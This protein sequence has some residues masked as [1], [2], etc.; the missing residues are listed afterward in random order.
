[1]KIN[2]LLKGIKILDIKGDDNRDVMGVEI[3]SR[4]ISSSYMFV[5]MRG[6]VTDGHTYIAKAIEKGASVIV[7]EELPSDIKE[8]VTYVRVESTEDCVGRISTVFHGNPSAHLRLVGVTGTNGKTTI[9]TLLYNMFRKF[10]HK[11]GLI[12]TVCNY[13]DE[14]K[15]ETTHTTPDAI[16]LN[17]LLAE[18]LEAG[19]EYVF[20]ECSSHAIVQKRI[21]GLTFAGGIFTNLTRD[22]LDYHKTFYYPGLEVCH[23]SDRI[24]MDFR[25][26]VLYHYLS[27]LIVGI[28]K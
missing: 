15:V 21:G 10:G 4:N 9:A 22:H 7:C 16:E 24:C 27:V 3:D 26:C 5:A 19:C 17:K 13:I 12:S 23:C 6:T 2:E 28:N 1:M 8:D 25:L 18:M 11:C 14:R 20:M